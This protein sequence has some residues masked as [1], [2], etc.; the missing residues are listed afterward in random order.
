MN[1]RWCNEVQ[2]YE[3]LRDTLLAL[4]S[5]RPWPQTVKGKAHRDG[6][7][8]TSSTLVFIHAVH[9]C[10]QSVRH[11]TSASLRALR[12]LG[13]LRVW[14]YYRKPRTPLAFWHSRSGYEVDFILT[15]RSRSK[16]RRRG[17]FRGSTCG[18][19]GRWAEE[20][21]VERSIVVCRADRPRREQG[22]RSGPWRSSWARCGTMACDPA[23]GGSGGC[24]TPVDRIILVL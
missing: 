16:R 21:L 13:S 22:S 18:A 7:S 11:L 10:P 3:V 9:R 20:R 8:S 23:D 17:W 19:C 5:C 4:R 6:A 2:W 15:T 14:I 1:R 24:C 12:L